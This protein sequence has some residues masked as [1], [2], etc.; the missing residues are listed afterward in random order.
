MNQRFTPSTLEAYAA[1]IMRANGVDEAQAASVARNLTWSELVGR[2]NF[3]LQR[4]PILIERVR[5]GVISC[6]CRT[7]LEMRSDA[8]AL[9]DGGGG[10]GHHVGEIGMRRA[11][12]LARTHGVGITAVRNSNF[13]GTGA[14]FVE[15]AAKADMI[16]L[17]MSNSFPKV[18]AHRGLRPVLGTNPFGLGAPRRNGESLLIDM[19]TSALAGSAVR[20]HLEK[21]LPL[22]EGLAIDAGG[23]P[24]TDP[25]RVDGGALLPFAGAKGFALSLIV[26]MIAGILNCCVV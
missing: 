9:L 3:G 15:I 10:F 20:E 13:F 11:I 6:P 25:K 22:P 14:Y 4:L 19:A 8:I 2:S 21:R 26:E 17:A 12:E 16:G 7:V 18:T 1:A 23:A 5:R 24:I